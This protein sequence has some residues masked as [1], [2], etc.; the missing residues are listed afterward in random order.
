MSPAAPPPLGSIRSSHAPAHDSGVTLVELV[1][2]TLIVAVAVSGVLAAMV[3]SVRG[4]AH[5][6]LE[7]Q[8]AAIARAYLEEIV[9]R[10]YHDP[11]DGPGAGPCP[12]AEASRDLYDNVCDYQG[13][14]D[15]GARDQS[16]G[17]IPA[18]V[19]YRVTVSVDPGATLHDLSGPADVVRVDVR[20]RHAAGVDLRLSA[21][22]TR[23]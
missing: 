8:G 12:P 4:S 19:A 6:V 17:A 23:Y 3:A 1:I 10:R 16:G 14:D 15:A 18:L 21:Y 5:P 22:R 2:S 9:L 7:E 13:L 11:Q 20:V